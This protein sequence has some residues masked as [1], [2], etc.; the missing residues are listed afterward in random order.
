MCVGGGGGRGV[1]LGF[2]APSTMAVI[3]GLFARR[4]VS[5]VCLMIVFSVTE[6]CAILQISYMVD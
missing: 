1:E 6:D 4:G 2:N 5:V 3:S